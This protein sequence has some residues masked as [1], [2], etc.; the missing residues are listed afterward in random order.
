VVEAFK[1][2]VVVKLAGAVTVRLADG[3]T[4][5]VPPVVSMIVVAPEL[6]IVKAPVEKG[7]VSESVVEALTLV[8]GVKLAR[9]ATVELAGGISP[10]PVSTVN[11]LVSPEMVN[12]TAPVETE[13]FELV[14]RAGVSVMFTERVATPL[15]EATEN[16]T[17]SLET[18]RAAVPIEIVSF[19]LWLRVKLGAGVVVEFSEETI[20]PLPEAADVITSELVELEAGVMLAGAVT[21]RFANGD[22]MAPDEP[23][24]ELIA[25]SP[26]VD[27]T[28]VPEASEL[29]TLGVAAMRRVPVS[30]T[31]ADVGGISPKDPVLN[32]RRV[33]PD[34]EKRPVPNEADSFTLEPGVRVAG[35]ELDTLPEGTT[36]PEA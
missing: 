2:W 14:L 12:T 13:L 31:N 10:L 27:K 25:I 26:D 7:T 8:D 34:V 28:P 30:E 20:I 18:V 33:A 35:A 21:V 9:G 1:L 16:T 23:L 24:P 36:S 19:G 29:L 6:V 15:P 17:V 5:P 11:T 32:T 3:D 22:W 4:T